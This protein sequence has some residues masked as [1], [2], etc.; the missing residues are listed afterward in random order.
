[1]EYMKIV[2]KKWLKMWFKA[3]RVVLSGRIFWPLNVLSVLEGVID[4]IRFV[5]CN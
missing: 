2:V 3:K 4:V 5:T 1:M